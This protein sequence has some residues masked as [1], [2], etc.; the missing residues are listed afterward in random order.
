VIYDPASEIIAVRQRI[1]AQELLEQS[2]TV[3]GGSTM[4]PQLQTR[5]ASRRNGALQ[6]S[7]ATFVL[8]V[9]C[10]HNRKSAPINS[11][12]VYAATSGTLTFP[13]HGFIAG[14]IVT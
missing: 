14:I 4:R 5:Y 12:R 10:K 8:I 11:K 1:L 7:Q 13:R 3:T 9:I 2:L 6:V